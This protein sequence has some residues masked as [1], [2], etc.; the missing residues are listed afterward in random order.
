MH[1]LINHQT[2][3]ERVQGPADSHLHVPPISTQLL[4]RATRCRQC[5]QSPPPRRRPCAEPSTY[6][7][8]LLEVCG[9]ELGQ[10]IAHETKHLWEMSLGFINQVVPQVV[11]S[12]MLS[13]AVAAGPLLPPA[14]PLHADRSAPGQAAARPA[15]ALPARA[16]APGA[17]GG[18]REAAA[19]Q[20]GN[21][22]EG[23]Q[24]PGGEAAATGSPGLEPAT[25]SGHDVS[26]AAQP[27]AAA[28][29]GL[30]KQ[31]AAAP[32]AAPSAAP[33]EAL[34]DEEVLPQ[35]AAGSKGEVAYRMDSAMEK[36]GGGPAAAMGAP[37]AQPLLAMPQAP[38]GSG[39]CKPRSGFEYSAS[40]SSELGQ[41]AAPLAFVLRDISLE[42]GGWV[43]GL[44]SGVHQ[45]N[46]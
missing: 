23:E 11:V 37:A 41:P 19:A 43:G 26:D 45:V 3:I 10:H 32:A 22:V 29:A 34:A 25:P 39:S 24:E 15:M 44:Q 2:A 30:G 38:G 36:E 28:A 21:G 40:H 35:Q 6:D 9:R 5:T 13:A 12:R 18:E 31:G 4:L 14:T 17:A 46:L 27:P 20:Q 33:A 42:V 1:G 8:A 16:A 7:L